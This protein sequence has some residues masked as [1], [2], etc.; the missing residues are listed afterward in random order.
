MKKI[1]I[2]LIQI[3]FILPSLAQEEAS[4]INSINNTRQGFGRHEAFDM[5]VGYVNPKTKTEGS[6][7]YFD[8]WNTEGIIYIK[9][10]GR[11]KIKKVNLNLYNNKLEAIYDENSV[12]TFNSE[13]LIKIIIDNKVFRI[14]KI[15]KELKIFELF[16]ND[17]I[18][19]Y[20]YYSVLYSKG[21][22]NPMHN[23]KT[24]KY[25]KKTK[26]YLYREGNLTKMKLSKNSFSKLF[27]SDKVSQQTIVKYIDNYELTLNKETDLIK[28]LNFVTK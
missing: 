3:I 1:I 15:D 17:K 21:S 14:F 27:Q 24:N 19:I 8:D 28:V 10:K 18:S 12:F 2:L 5:G 25:I 11:Y 20:R 4:E 22:K 6:A 26:Y 23:R 7:Y 16:F 13:N 9:D